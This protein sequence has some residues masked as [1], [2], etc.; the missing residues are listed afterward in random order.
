MCADTLKGDAVAVV[1]ACAVKPCSLVFI[2]SDVIVFALRTITAVAVKGDGGGDR[3]VQGHP[4]VR[5]DH[6]EG[7]RPL[8]HLPFCHQRLL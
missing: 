4:Q 3:A 5:G 7:K 8:L 1:Y 2:G 6:P